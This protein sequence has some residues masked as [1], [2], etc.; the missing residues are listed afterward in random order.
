MLLSLVLFA[1]I[2]GAFQKILAVDPSGD[3]QVAH[4]R[5]LCIELA[6]DFVGIGLGDTHCLG[7]FVYFKVILFD[8]RDPPFLLFNPE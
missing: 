5:K 1:T 6:D 4:F 7:D 2:T 8:L 3:G